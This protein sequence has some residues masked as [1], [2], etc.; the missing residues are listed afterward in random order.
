MTVPV[1][2]RVYR[3]R[4]YRP[5]LKGKR[6]RLLARGTMNSALVE[7]EGGEKHVVSRNAIRKAKSPGQ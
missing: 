2:D 5:E 6:C 3:W 1:Y 7:F 4:R